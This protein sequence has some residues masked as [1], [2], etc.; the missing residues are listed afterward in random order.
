MV[1]KQ[2]FVALRYAIAKWS[3]QTKGEAL[4]VTVGLFF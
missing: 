1:G 3:D 2:H 4:L